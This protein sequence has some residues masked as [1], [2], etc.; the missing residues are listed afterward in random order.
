MRPELRSVPAPHFLEASDGQPIRHEELY[1]RALYVKR[2]HERMVLVVLYVAHTL[3]LSALHTWAWS[4]SSLL[5]IPKYAS[6]I[7]GY[8]F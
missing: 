5:R 8:L 7:H 2:G 1:T 4:P 3:I 6:V